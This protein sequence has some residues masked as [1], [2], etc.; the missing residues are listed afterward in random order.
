MLAFIFCFL[1]ELLPKTDHLEIYF[2]FQVSKSIYLPI[3]G[4]GANEYS[5]ASN[6]LLARYS[7]RW[8]VT[9]QNLRTSRLLLSS[10]CKFLR[11]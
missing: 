2:Q 8:D 9:I 7:D 6:L 5:L 10:D 1:A 3:G 4:D 11:E